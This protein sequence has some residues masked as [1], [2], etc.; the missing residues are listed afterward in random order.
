MG[1]ATVVAFGLAA[2]CATATKSGSNPDAN[3]N[4][5]HDSNG[6]QFFDAPNMQQHDAPMNSGPDAAQAITLSETP[7]ATLAAVGSTI[8]CNNGT[9]TADNIWYRQYQL[10][11]FPAIT[12]GL[13][14][15]S[16][17]FGIEQSS[18]AGTI[19]IK[20]MTYTGSVDSLDTTKMSSLKSA[21]TSPADTSSPKTVSVPIV[22]DIPA[23]GKFVVEVSAP[24]DTNIGA[25]VLGSTSTAESHPGY[26]SSGTS[27]CNGTTPVTTASLG[28]TTHSVIDVVGTH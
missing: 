26:W 4:G 10:S 1:I 11:D 18:A 17:S 24:D 19:T 15:T 22:A 9:S 27:G 3:G 25:F 7:G 28:Q 16:V 8:S 5:Q 2:G 14:I 21:T 6:M 23:G 12:G 20:I 13:H